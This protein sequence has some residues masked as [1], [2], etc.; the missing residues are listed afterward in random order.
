MAT[1]QYHRIHIPTRFPFSHE[2]EIDVI[3]QKMSA[4][5]NGGH[6][7]QDGFQELITFAGHKLQ[8]RGVNYIKLSEGNA[9]STVGKNDSFISWDTKSAMIWER[10]PKISFDPHDIRI[11]Q[12]YFFP[13]NQPCYLSSIVYIPKLRVFLASALDMTFQ[14]F[15]RNFKHM[16]NIRHEERAILTMEYDPEK[17]IL[18]CA[19]ASG[20]SVWRFYRNSTLDGSHVIEKLFTFEGC[21]SWVGI[22]LY[23]AKFNRVYAL[24]DTSGI[25]TCSLYNTSGVHLN[26]L[27]FIVVSVLSFKRRAVI[28]KL[29]NI[30]D[31]PVTR[32]CW[33][34]RSQFYLTGCR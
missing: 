9:S 29:E 21:D 13:K 18:L 8:V 26:N 31:A 12:K 32:V 19:G 5:T 11:I 14:V 4:L 28:S 6:F 34:E 7:L 10:N 20:I 30:H 2:G 15:D 24:Q 16:E 1:P 33:Y 27:F 3:F 22:M 23:D 17:G 25:T